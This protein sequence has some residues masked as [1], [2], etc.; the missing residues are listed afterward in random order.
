MQFPGLTDVKVTKKLNR[1]FVL[2]R[3][4]LKDGVII[5]FSGGVDS[6]MLLWAANEVQ[7]KYG[8]KLIALTADSP[9][10]PRAELAEAESLARIFGITHKIIKSKELTNDNY[11]RNDHNRCYYCKNELFRLTGIQSHNEDCKWVLYGYNHSDKTD[12]RPG[13]KAALENDIMSPLAE[14]NLTKNEI[15]EILK[16]NGIAIA[17]KPASPCLSS[18]IMTGISVNK[19]RLS[20]IEEMEKIIHQ[21]GIRVCRVRLCCENEIEFLRIEIACEEMQAIFDIRERLVNEGLKRG[22]RWVTLDLA[23]YNMGGGVI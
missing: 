3:T 5:A 8:G 14:V 11:L 9:S 1:L 13:H 10:L 12:E 7:S 15:K 23:G 18:R 17:D 2:L 19:K 22:Y 21:A 20:D 6:T 4:Y 16:S